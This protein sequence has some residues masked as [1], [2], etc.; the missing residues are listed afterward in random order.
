M[1]SLSRPAALTT[2]WVG[3]FAEDPSAVPVD[4][5]LSGV[6]YPGEA[7]FTEFWDARWGSLPGQDAMFRVVFLGSSNPVSPDEIEDDRIIVIAPSGDMPPELRPV[8]REAAALR[9][10]RAGYA[11]S[12]DP[13]L[14][15]LAHAIELRESGRHR[16]QTRWAE[17]GPT[18]TSSPGANVPTFPRYSPPLNAQVPIHGLKRSV[19]G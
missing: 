18:A 15:R 5:Y 14:S 19:H 7:V 3:A 6:R 4:I 17:D 1:T 11:V 12:S 13:A 2:G 8:A 16:S 10:T 9:E